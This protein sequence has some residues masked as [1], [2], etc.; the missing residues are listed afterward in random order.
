MN[1]L[2][3]GRRVQLRLIEV[4]LHLIN[5]LC[6]GIRILFCTLIGCS[7]GEF[8]LRLISVLELTS[9]RR[10]WE[11]RGEF[12]L[13][14]TSSNLIGCRVR[15]RRSPS[16][17][18]R[19]IKEWIIYL[20]HYGHVYLCNN[21]Q[22]TSTKYYL[23]YIFINTDSKIIK[24]MQRI[25]HIILKQKNSNSGFKRLHL[26]FNNRGCNSAFVAVHSW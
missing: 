10:I 4:G 12:E 5:Q 21:Y 26:T 25:Q 19:T 1:S 11:I 2:T 17:N 7:G 15:R 20:W 9:P 22:Y 23:Y 6:H 14:L 16:L 13:R 24:Q 18:R 3:I 8:E